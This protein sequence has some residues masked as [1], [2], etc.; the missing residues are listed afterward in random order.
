MRQGLDKLLAA[1]SR[2]FYLTI[3]VL[4]PALRTPVGLGY[5]LARASDTVADSAEASPAARL[6]ALRCMGEAL[7][8][9]GLPPPDLS[10][11]ASG[12]PDPAE[13]ALLATIPSLWEALAEA[14]RADREEIVAVLRVILEGQALDLTRFAL[15]EG[16]AVRALATA[17][18]LEDYTY[19]VAGCVGVFWTRI[20]LLHLPRYAPGVEPEA[21][22]RLGA[23][24]GQ[25]LQL[26]NILRD[27]PADL[28]QGRCYLPAA[29]LPVSPEALRADPAAARAVC[30]RWMERTRERL[31]DGFAY[32][33]AI[34]P[35]R[36]RLACFLPWALGVR[37]VARM[38]R[39]RPLETAVR[40]KVPRPEVRRIFFWGI[41]GA[42]GNAPL[43]WAAGRVRKA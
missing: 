34:R 20:C 5:L 7:A 25:G 30:D 37:T 19:R 36:I 15:G 27:A 17:G 35:W 41:V 13:R 2:S 4:P 12:V 14:S 43:R 29:E 31:A 28:V 23:S 3:R 9:P 6:E 8:A 40:V 42:L 10:S 24:F 39:S 33:E 1:V 16:P 32:I 11:F 21:L 26:V 22:A 18:E 38:E